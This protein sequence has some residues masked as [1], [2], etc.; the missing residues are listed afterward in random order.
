MRRRR[1]KLRRSRLAMLGET[2]AQESPR[3][4]KRDARECLEVGG[5]KPPHYPFGPYRVCL[6]KN[7]RA[8]LFKNK[9]IREVGCGTFACAY[10]HPN[11][12]L[13][14]KITRDEQDVG[15]LLQARGTGLVPEVYDAYELRGGGRSLKDGKKTRVYAVIAERLRPLTDAQKLRLRPFEDALQYGVS[16]LMS[17]QDTCC[18]PYD[19]MACNPLCLA[20]L[21]LGRGLQ[22]L[23]IDWLD[24][25]GGNVGYDSQGKLRVLDV[26]RS[27]V[28]APALQVLDGR[29]RRAQRVMR[30]RRRR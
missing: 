24:T 21:H 14:V 3:G 20:V 27:E 6:T 15:G 1:H 10:E 11:P 19:P 18:D 26:G 16:G 22:D 12:N 4:G 7:Q 23:G 28:L 9:P 29:K 25:H 13:V 2:T 8:A 30:W 5:D 17:P